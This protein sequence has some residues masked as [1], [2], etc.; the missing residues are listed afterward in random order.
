M[1]EQTL[2]LPVEKTTLNVWNSCKILKFESLK[3]YSIYLSSN[4]H[5]SYTFEAV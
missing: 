3:W 5:S 2:M 4:V 1:Y